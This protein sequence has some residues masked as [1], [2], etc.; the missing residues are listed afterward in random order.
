[1]DRRKIYELLCEVIK[2]AELGKKEC[3]RD[4]FEEWRLC[5]HAWENIESLV[6][7][8]S[9]TITREHRTMVELRR[10]KSLSKIINSKD[11]SV[12]NLSESNNIAWISGEI[13]SDVS[14]EDRPFP[15]IL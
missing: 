1:M 4:D 15:G 6:D 12:K 14:L 8:I 2:E 3:L 11:S 10:V 9:E 7:K 5:N 13:D